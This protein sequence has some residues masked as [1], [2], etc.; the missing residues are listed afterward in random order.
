LQRQLIGLVG[1]LVVSFAAASIGAVAS[2]DAASFYRQLSRPEWA[3]PSWLFAPVWTVLYALMGVA[4]WLVWRSHGFKASRTSLVLFL[5]QLAANALWTWLFFAWH[6]GAGAFAEILILWALIVATIASFRS[7]SVPAA[8]LL[9]PYLV[10]V[11][12]ATALTFSVWRL[13]PGVL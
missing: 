8:L 7:V 12:F 5:V 6:Q 13:N 10:W 1:W 9:V 3:P 4:A 2:L 11:T